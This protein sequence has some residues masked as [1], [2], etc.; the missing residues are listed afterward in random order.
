MVRSINFL[1][2]R[3]SSN[4]GNSVKSSTTSLALSPQAATTI[5]SASAFCEILCCNTVFPVPKGPGVKPVP[6]S[7]MGL[8][9]SM[10]RMPVSSVLKGRGLD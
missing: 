3:G 10:V 6:P 5:K 7:A 8:R 9:V 4:S 2:V 1:P